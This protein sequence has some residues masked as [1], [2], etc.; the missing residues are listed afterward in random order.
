MRGIGLAAAALLALASPASA[1]D[2]WKIGA[3]YPLTGN[4][5]LLGNENLYGVNTALG[6]FATQTGETRRQQGGAHT[7]VTHGLRPGGETGQQ[8]LFLRRDTSEQIRRQQA[9][10]QPTFIPECIR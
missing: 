10:L 7:W 9:G 6:R 8:A 5:A 4:L 2:T 1:Q 3:L